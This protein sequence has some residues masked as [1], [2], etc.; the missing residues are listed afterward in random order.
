MKKF[1]LIIAGGF[2]AL[3]FIYGSLSALVNQG[4][5]LTAAVLIFGAILGGG[6]GILMFLRNTPDSSNEDKTGE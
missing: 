1:G 3:L 6:T 2:A 4:L 5:S